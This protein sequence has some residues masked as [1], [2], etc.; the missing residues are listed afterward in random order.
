MADFNPDKFLAETA[1]SS[2]GGFDPD[3]FLASAPAAAPPDNQSGGHFE[4]ELSDFKKAAT[5]YIRSLLN[6][7]T[8][9]HAADI[10]GFLDPDHSADYQREY[11]SASQEHPAVEAAGALA[12]PMPGVGKLRAL[13]GLGGFAARELAN[14]VIGAGA[15]LATGDTDVS[16]GNRALLGAGAGVL[17]G[18][19]AEGLGALAGKA[20]EGVRSAVADQAQLVNKGAQKTMRSARSAVGGETA[21]VLKNFDT[22][23]SIAENASGIHPSEVVAAARAKLSD[24]KYQDVVRSAAK[25]AVDLGS[26]K[27]SGSLQTARNVLDS[28]TAATAPDAIDA[29]TDAALKNPVRTQV[30]PR[31]AKY[32]SR[33]IPVMVGAHMGGM[34]GAAAGGV[35]AA[36]M[37]H[38]GTALANMAKSPAV[39][40]GA[41]GLVQKAAAPLGTALE[42]DVPGLAEGA[43]AHF[44]G[45]I[46]PGAVPAMAGDSAPAGQQASAPQPA[47]AQPPPPENPTFKAMGKVGAVLQTDPGRLGKFGV[48]LTN[49][50]QQRGPEA[51]AAAHFVLSQS[52]PEYQRHLQSLEDGHSP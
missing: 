22:M 29:A 19:A 46:L 16:P 40:A 26:D 25:S 27:L 17:G 44:G 13:K 28:A 4:Q 23:Q 36:A 50:A 2:G 11:H 32:A 12:A 9:R 42:K 41:Y 35:L 45:G 43:A 15:G 14:G 38:P 5:P 51:A 24:P 3:K 31:L 21:A 8:Y 52:N 1:P 6:G 30:L 18:A 7:A 39:R 34:P 47:A 37:G 20:A 10:A 49:I 48:A 33:V